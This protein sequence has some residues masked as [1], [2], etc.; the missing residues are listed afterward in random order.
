VLPADV[1]LL[2]LA[3][4][5]PTLLLWRLLVRAMQSRAVWLPTRLS[6]IMLRC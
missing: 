4:L 1:L 5:V 3:V 2:L 6:R